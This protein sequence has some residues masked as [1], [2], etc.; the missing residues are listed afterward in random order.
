MLSALIAA[1]KCSE[2]CGF[3]AAFVGSFCYGSY[4]VPVKATASIDVHPL[5]LQ[6]YKTSVVFASSWAFLFLVL[7]G[8]ARNSSWTPLGLVSGFL[9]VTG[10]C[11]GNYAIRT[12]GIAVAVGTWASV[13]VLVN[14]VWGILVFHEPVHSVPGTCGAFFFLG[15]G[16]VGMTR[17]S[18][19]KTTS[20]KKESKQVELMGDQD[21]VVIR[22]G[23]TSRRR[24][25]D[26]NE[27]T[28]PITTIP[29][30]DET[31]D[32]QSVVD[33][34][35]EE[36]DRDIER[37]DLI[38]Q[39]ITTSEKKNVKLVHVLGRSFTP[40]QAGVICAVMNGLL[41]G[42]SLVPLHYAKEQGISDTSYFVS[43]SSGA[44]IANSIY[45]I[46]YF[47]IISTDP[48][49]GGSIVKPYQP[50]PR[51]HFRQLWFKMLIAGFLLS[52]GMLG[53]IVA[54]SSLGQA[55]GNS[56]IQSKILVSGLWG[57]CCY[58]EIKDRRSI[59]NWFLSA[60]LSVVSILWLAYERTSIPTSDAD[61]VQPR[62]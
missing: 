8:E 14:F 50:V 2:T 7:D 41:S 35:D 34:D 59:F 20:T 29:S 44:L 55:V 19:P 39:K 23:L 57:I 15:L 4:G 53:S 36:V 46:L 9:W 28:M 22:D 18:S 45:L 3:L 21:L 40:R 26:D 1:E 42:S 33:D 60:S 5:I 37:K 52:G 30:Q 27:E 43:F 31:D 51:W 6:T 54:T 10:G 25:D 16:L 32:D 56:L 13:M 24:A 17:F 61:A 48:S 62:S 47:L 11:C 12:A 58:Q 49:R 38:N